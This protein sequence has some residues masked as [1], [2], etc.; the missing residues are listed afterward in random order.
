MPEKKRKVNHAVHTQRSSVGGVSA[1][2]QP[3]S[4]TGVRKASA[5]PAGKGPVTFGQY[6]KPAPS[7]LLSNLSKFSGGGPGNQEQVTSIQRS[8]S[9]LARPKPEPS[10]VSNTEVVAVAPAVSQPASTVVPTRDDRLAIVEQLE[11]GPIDHKPPPDDPHFERL[12]P[13][14]CIRLSYV[15]SLQLN[16]IKWLDLICAG[17]VC[18]R[19]MICRNISEADITSHHLNSTPA[20]GCYPISRAT[21]CL[22][23]VTGSQLPLLLSAAL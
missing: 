19:T 4:A 6:Q 14:S 12:E 15:L 8:H 13:N 3:L 20:Y 11:V 23:K 5:R 1:V 9:L 7:N 22:S 16:P 18:C 21:M 10:L 17:P 2:S